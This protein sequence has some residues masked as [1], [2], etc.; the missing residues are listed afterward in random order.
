M[1]N[2]PFQKLQ[3]DLDIAATHMEKILPKEVLDAFEKSIQDLRTSDSGRGLIAG[4]KAPDFTLVNSTGQK[5]TLSEEIVKGPVVL[6][7]YRG[8]WCPFCN[9]ELKAYQRMNDDIKA[10]GGQL[11]AVS[12]QTPNHSSS[13]QDKNEL[14]FHVLSDL[15]NQT[16]EK[17]NLKFK[18]PEYLYHIYRS[19]DISL[20]TF[21][22]DHSWELP[23]PATYV[24][25][26]AGI[27]RL[28]SVEVDYKKRL[29]PSKVL[30]ILQSL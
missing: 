22:G 2:T 18:L 7:F 5:I 30:H 24:I 13:V 20:E 6:I 21:N 17:Y 19:L 10:T 27:I 4:A 9:L 14:N 8:I 11:I 3:S 25:D 16:A 28:A 15:Q 23:V 12:P 1:E 29:E 26:K